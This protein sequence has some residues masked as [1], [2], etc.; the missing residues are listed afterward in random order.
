MSY[1]LENSEGYHI[2]QHFVLNCHNVLI[3]FKFSF[4]KMGK[5]YQIKFKEKNEVFNITFLTLKKT[6]LIKYSLTN[7]SYQYFILFY[8]F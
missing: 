6:V 5:M 2:C 4:S 1:L 8:Y 3:F 7:A